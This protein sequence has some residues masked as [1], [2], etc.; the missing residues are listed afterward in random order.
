MYAPSV[1]SR[2]HWVQ[3]R[4]SIAGPFWISFGRWSLVGCPRKSR[5][6]HLTYVEFRLLLC[7]SYLWSSII[8][9]FPAE[10]ESSQHLGI[11]ILNQLF[12]INCFSSLTFK[13]APWPEKVP[14]PSKKSLPLAELPKSS[15]WVP[16]A[17]KAATSK[18]LSSFATTANKSCFEILLSIWMTSPATR[19]LT[20]QSDTIWI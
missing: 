8:S 3:T 19:N 7:T 16:M 4:S 1:E 11:S 18:F 20:W 9:L 13:W 17:S 15:N 5:P 6:I 10:I 12:L 2:G 14:L